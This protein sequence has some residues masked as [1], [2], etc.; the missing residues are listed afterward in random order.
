MSVPQV[1]VLG[2]SFF[3]RYIK[4]LLSSGENQ[5]ENHNCANDATLIILSLIQKP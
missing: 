1:S 4:D 2:P 3:L 5:P